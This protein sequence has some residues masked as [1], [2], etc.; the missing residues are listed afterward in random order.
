MNVTRGM[1]RRTA[2]VMR[3][4]Q[5]VSGPTLVAGVDLAKRASIAMFVR[6]DDKQRVDHLR[7]RPGEVGIRQLVARGQGLLKAQGLSKLVVAMEATGNLWKIAARACE[8][9]GVEYVIV[10]SFVLSRAR[11]FD[12]L[13]RDKND[14]RDAGLIADLAADRRFTDVKLDHGPWAQLR[15]YADARDEQ[16]VRRSADLQEQ[17]SF[18]ELVWPELLEQ[19][20]DLQ[21]AHVQATL[22]LGLSPQQIASMT[23]S[24]FIRLLRREQSER[25]FLEFIAE[26]IWSAATQA[27]PWDE[28]EAAALRWQCS[29]ER[30]L[31]ADRSIA[32]YEGRM[33]ATFEQTGLG[34]MQHQIAGLGDVALAG[35]MGLAETFGASM[36]AGASSS[37]RA[38]VPP[39]AA[40][41]TRSPKAVFIVAAGRHSGR[42]RGRR[43]RI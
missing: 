5:I 22:R 3:R 23:R 31:A 2:K 11:E 43:R 6:A 42:W 14:R 1:Q 17:R 4:S 21:G 30:V 41:A 13:T 9:L 12:D 24:R 8:D 33:L 20:P 19:L 28:S 25:R 40:P 35:I 39:T 32:L 16:R 36:T 38:A 27:K 37:W 15:L 26:R 7:I 29:A 18:L 34:W 10:Q